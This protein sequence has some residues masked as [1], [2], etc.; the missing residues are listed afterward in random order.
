MGVGQHRIDLHPFRFTSIGP[1]I[2]KLW[3]IGCLTDL[4]VKE[5]T[6]SKINNN[7]DDDDDDHNNNNNKAAA[8]AAAADDDDDDDDDDILKNA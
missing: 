7:N 4:A 6:H 1:T 5:H 8:A 3:P 2:R